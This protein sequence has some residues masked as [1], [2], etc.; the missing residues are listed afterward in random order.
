MITLENIS[1]ETKKSKKVTIEE[2]RKFIKNQS[3]NEN[4]C[5]GFAGI[6]FRNNVLEEE[7][8]KVQMEQQLDLILGS[9]ENAKKIFN[10]VQTMSQTD[11]GNKLAVNYAKKLNLLVMALGSDYGK[12]V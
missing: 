1:L 2:I 11:M 5:M 6:G 9:L 3:V 4:V 10:K 8:D 12:F 7:Q